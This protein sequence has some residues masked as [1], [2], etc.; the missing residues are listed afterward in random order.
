MVNRN[1]NY[2]SASWST[3]PGGE[4][5]AQSIIKSDWN[6]L[7][8]DTIESSQKHSEEKP[9]KLHVSR[10]LWQV[11]AGKKPA[12]CFMTQSLSGFLSNRALRLSPV[13]LTRSWI[14]LEKHCRRKPSSVPWADFCF[15]FIIQC[16]KWQ[17]LCACH[18]VNSIQFNS[19]HA[20]QQ[21]AINNWS[22]QHRRRYI[23]AVI[24]YLTEA[25]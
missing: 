20:P 18:Q 14:F 23:H 19:L 9:V 2:T 12:N 4:V 5:G 8:C 15:F 21:M 16:Y 6:V 24:D 1:L 25:P 22:S 7:T 3:L 13:V 17:V 10:S 11:P